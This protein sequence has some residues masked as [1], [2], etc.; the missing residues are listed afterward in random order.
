M[1]GRGFGEVREFEV[2]DSRFYAGSAVQNQAAGLM[3]LGLR[4]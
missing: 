3:V 1:S 2:L 4:V